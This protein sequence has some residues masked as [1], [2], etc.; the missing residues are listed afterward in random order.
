MTLNITLRD[1]SLALKFFISLVYSPNKPC[2]FHLLRC[3]CRKSASLDLFLFL[4]VTDTG[5]ITHTHLP[6]PD[7]NIFNVCVCVVLGFSMHPA[8]VFIL[9]SSSWKLM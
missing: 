3:G 6:V 1:L 2:Q 5:Y 9:N 7:I 4:E 8:L